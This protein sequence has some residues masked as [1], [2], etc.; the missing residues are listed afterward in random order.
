MRTRIG[1]IDII[2][3]DSNVIVF[4]EVKTRYSRRFGFP[5][6][7]VHHRKLK[8]IEKVG[9]YFRLKYPDPLLEA[10]RIDVITIEL[11]KNNKPTRKEIIKNASG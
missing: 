1:E 4:A 11:D 6:E 8:T 9:Q 5:E 10:E 2:A 7:Y 3:V